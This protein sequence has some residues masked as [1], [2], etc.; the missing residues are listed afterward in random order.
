MKFV[1]RLLVYVFGLLLMAFGVSFATNSNLG[2]SPVSSLP[3]AVGAVTGISVG[4]CI[5]VVYSLYVLVQILL[6]RKEF[7]IKNLLQVVFATLF[8]S[9]VDLTRMAMGNFSIPGYLGQLAMMAISMVLVAFGLVFYL[10]ADIV[11]MPMEG[12]VLAI[13]KKMPRSKFHNVKMIC[14]ITSV[15]LAV[16]IS[17]MG[18]GYVVGV[19]EGTVIAALFISRVMALITPYVRPLVYQFCFGTAETVEALPEE[20]VPVY[21]NSVRIWDLWESGHLG[22]GGAMEAY[23]IW[24]M[25]EKAGGK[26]PQLKSPTVQSQFDVAVWEL[27][28]SGHISHL[29][30]GPSYVY[31]MWESWELD[32]PDKPEYAP[33]NLWE[34]DV[35]SHFIP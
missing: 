32:A 3:S 34:S 23:E 18:L 30:Y 16:A 22:A 20:P 10:T 5:I 27:W 6:L 31:E 1:N 28:E 25:W 4:T 8:G 21:T 24:D 2:V 12:M 7:H 29:S 26:I 11:P 33:R 15:C 17:A 14:D 13:T 19:R 35:V 9:F